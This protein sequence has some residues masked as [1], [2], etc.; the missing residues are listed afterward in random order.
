LAV[1][2]GGALLFAWS[3]VY[4]VAADKPQWKVIAWYLKEVRNRSIAV[5]SQNISP[6]AAGSVKQNLIENASDYYSGTC[7]ICHGAQGK[8]PAKFSRGLDPTPPEFASPGWD[9]PEER[10]MFWIIKNGIKMTAMASFGEEVFKDDQI[11]AMV[12]FLKTLPRNEGQKG[13][14]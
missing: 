10:K 12:T 5:R 6:P 14:L 1:F 3:G 11:W 8:P 2:I 7:V 9:R 4:D 13:A